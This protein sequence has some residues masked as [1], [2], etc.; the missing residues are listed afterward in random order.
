[1]RLR[2]RISDLVHV[3][4]LAVSLAATSDVAYRIVGFLGIGLL[5]LIIGLIAFN[6]DVQQ[7]GRLGTIRHQASTLSR[8]LLWTECL[9]PRRLKGGPGSSETHPATCSQ[10]C[11]RRADHHRIVAVFCRPT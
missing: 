1:M 8:W 5:G 10:D 9:E 6:V 7:G 11:E 4:L 3:L 2:I